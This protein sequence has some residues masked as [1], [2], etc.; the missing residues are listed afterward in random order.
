MFP[1]AG[2]TAATSTLANLIACDLFAT[3]NVFLAGGLAQTLLAGTTTGCPTLRDFRSV[4]IPAAEGSILIAA[5]RCRALY[6]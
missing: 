3:K 1:L 6:A 5:D 4:G 2:S